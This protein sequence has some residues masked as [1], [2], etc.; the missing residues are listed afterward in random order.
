[1]LCDT[2]SPI[3]DYSLISQIFQYCRGNGLHGVN[4]DNF[5]HKLLIFALEINNKKQKQTMR[6]YTAAL[7]KCLAATAISTSVS[8]SGFAQSKTE[9][10]KYGDFNSWITRNIPESQLIGGQTKT[11]YEIGPSQTIDGA[12]AYSN[13]GGS[14]WATSNV[15]AKVVGI[16]KGSCAVMPDTRSGSDRCARL[17]TIMERCKAIG[18]I[19]I[20][21]VVAGSIFLGEMLEPV[22]STSDPYSKMEMGIP[23]TRRPKAITFDY[24]LSM[25][26]NAVRTYSS[27]FGK[28]KTLPGH[29][30]AEVMV[31]LQRRWEDDK[32]NIYARRVGTARVRFDRPT[33][34]W[35]NG[36]RL[37]VMYGDITSNPDYKPYMG[38]IP[39][40]R[41]YYARNSKGKMV[42]VT[43]TGWD[44]KDAT[45][46][47]IILMAS[48]A[49][50]E[51][52]T[53]T[54]GLTFWIDNIG[55]TY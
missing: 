21:V 33:T 31:M 14:P 27:G 8:L 47:H 38:L 39:A 20:D 13:I 18:L 1:M 4:R 2:L 9:I 29:E 52:Y 23:F 53:G 19:N 5:C 43:E 35:V 34:D 28:K 51:A 44:S 24:R 16:S 11:L 40:E 32:G 41:S 55:A 22:S 37:P 36:Y 45:P 50:G 46:T 3:M 6:T 49:S 25:P 42:P 48:A 30:S 54:L 15:Y 10:F 12:K 17:T 7:W 26:E